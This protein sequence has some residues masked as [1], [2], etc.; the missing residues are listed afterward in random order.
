MVVTQ[1][2]GTC[3]WQLMLTCYTKA[4]LAYLKTLLTS[5]ER[6]LHQPL[7][8]SLIIAYFGYETSVVIQILGFWEMKKNGYFTSNAKY[9]GFEHRA[10]MQV[11]MFCLVGLYNLNIIEVLAL[12]VE[13]YSLPYRSSEHIDGS[14]HKMEITMNR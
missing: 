4:M 13:W 14:L 11:L 6:W 7:L 10:I 12:F 2:W 3:T 5:F 8:L 9:A 1:S